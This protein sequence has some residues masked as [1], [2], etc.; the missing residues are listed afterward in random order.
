[1]SMQQEET[2]DERE[3][4]LWLVHDGGGAGQIA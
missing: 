4:T 1:M 3:L 2:A